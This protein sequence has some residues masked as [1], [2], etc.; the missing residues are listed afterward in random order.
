MKRYYC[1]YFDR[2]YLVMGLTLIESLKRNERNPFLIFVVC[3]DE[4]TRVILDRL[5]LPQVKTIALHEIEERNFPLLNAKQNRSLVEFYWTLTPTVIV[6]I[7]EEYPEIDILTYLDADLFF[8]SSP[9]PIYDELGDHSILIHGHRF[10]GAQKFLERYGKYNVGLLCFRPDANG[11]KAVSWWRD[12]CIEWCYAR[13]EGGKYGDQLYL[14]SFHQKFEGVVELKNIG[15]GVGPWNHIQYAFDCD[16]NGS[17]IVDNTPLVFYHFHSLTFVEPDIIIPTKFVSN[18]LTKDILRSCYLPYLNRLSGSISLARTALPEFNFN[19][20]ND[21]IL[22]DKHVF[23]ARESQFQRIEKSKIPHRMM[24]LDEEW[25]CYFPEE[26]ARMRS[27]GSI[28]FEK[29]LF[30]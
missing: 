5:N 14:N 2:N 4:I 29:T 6:R 8:Y 17:V 26:M 22:H 3:L 7:L 24:H 23:L 1:T 19:L 13:L 10:S 18:P 27:D 12:R 21:G 30:A 25:N 11:I 20:K 15:A 16:N 9:D 28:N